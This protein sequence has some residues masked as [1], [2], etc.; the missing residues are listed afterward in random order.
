M[1]KQKEKNPDEV[2]GGKSK[3]AA[4]Q[5]LICGYCGQNPL[6]HQIARQVSGQY[7][8]TYGKQRKTT[9]KPK[10]SS[11]GTLL[12]FFLVIIKLLSHNS[13]VHKD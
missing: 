13:G 10:P 4:S 9:R 11:F 1:D 3:F 6:S 2:V 5:L 12:V 8:T 7:K